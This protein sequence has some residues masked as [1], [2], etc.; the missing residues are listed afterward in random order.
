MWISSR[1]ISLFLAGV[2][3][4]LLSASC[5]GTGNVTPQLDGTWEVEKIFLYS[6]RVLDEGATLIIDGRTW[7][8]LSAGGPCSM[9]NRTETK[10]ILDCDG[11]G[12]GQNME[13]LELTEDRL[14]VRSCEPIRS[15]CNRILYRRVEPEHLEAD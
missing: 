1:I 6:G 10:F 15:Y 13:I 12:K 5:N 4:T 9:K 2:G 3:M 14:T 8:Y 7:Q 11:P